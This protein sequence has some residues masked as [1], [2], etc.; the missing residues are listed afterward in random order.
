M[1]R[2][3]SKP[4]RRVADNHPAPKP[5]P[6]ATPWLPRHRVGAR[7]AGGLLH[8]PDLPHRGLDPHRVARQEVAEGLALQ[9][10][11]HHA[12]AVHGRSISGSF[13]AAATPSRSFCWIA[14]STR[15]WVNSPTQR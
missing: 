3:G 1:R 8:P 9:V 13:T 15:A 5:C 11:D 7:D 2:D 14:G 4:L 12:G 10:L 6:S